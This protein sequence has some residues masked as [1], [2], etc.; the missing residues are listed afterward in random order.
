VRP[1]LG[2]LGDRGHVFS[3][4]EAQAITRH[5]PH[6]RRVDVPGANHYTLLLH[7]GPPALPVVRDFLDQTLEINAPG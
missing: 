1:A 6:C 4:A 7:S 3:E 2:L 5:I